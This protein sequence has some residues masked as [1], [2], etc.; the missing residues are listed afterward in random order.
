M[1]ESVIPT[2][3]AG[4]PDKTSP[5]LFPV[6]PHRDKQREPC[7][8]SRPDK[9]EYWGKGCTVILNAIYQKDCLEFFVLP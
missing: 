8:Q 1:R 7:A 3:Y 2:K 6:H 4:I 5:Q 9:E